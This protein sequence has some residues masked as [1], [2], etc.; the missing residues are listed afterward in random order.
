[1]HLDVKNFFNA[2]MRCSL[3]FM[4]VNKMSDE[5]LML[6]HL[7]LTTDAERFVQMEEQTVNTLFDNLHCC[8]DL[9]NPAKEKVLENTSLIKTDTPETDF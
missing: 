5:E 8:Y 9:K 1:M 3:S 2:N 6:F 4:I 7:N